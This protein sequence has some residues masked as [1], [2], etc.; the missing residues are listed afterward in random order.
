MKNEKLYKALGVF[1]DTM[2]V[3]VVKTLEKHFP[4]KDW[5]ELLYE[6]LSAERQRNWN[7]N[8]EEFA[9]NG[10]P[11]NNLIDYGNLPSF[12]IGFKE[13][14][15]KEFDDKKDANRLINMLLELADVRNDCQHF[16]DVDADE[17]ERAFSNMK[18]VARLIKD[19]KLYQ[20]IV[21]IA[22]KNE[23][24]PAREKRPRIMVGSMSAS[25]VTNDDNLMAWF[26]NVVPHE[27]IRN[28]VLDE[29][30]FAANLWEVAAGKAPAVYLN[31]ATFFEKTYVT[32]GIRD[33]ASRVVAAMNG[34][35]TQNRVISLKTG[36][37]GG[38]THSLIT[39]Y[40]IVKSGSDFGKMDVAKELLKDG[41]MPDFDNARIAVFTHDTNDVAQGREVDGIT[42]RTLW[43]EIAYQL[44][45]LEAYQKVKENDEK[46]LAPTSVVFKP[47]LEGATPCLILIDEL[48]SY[49]LRAHGKKVGGTTLYNETLSFVQTLTEVV[50]DV[51]RC[52]LILTLPA[53]VTEVGDA[54]MG[55]EILTGLQ[56]RVSRIAANISPV[57]NEEIYEVVRRRLF[58][59][60][61][62]EEVVTSVAARY[63]DMYHNRRTDLPDDCDR[64]EYYRRM[65]KSYPFQPELIDMFR[66]RWGNDSRFQRTRGVLRLLASIVQDL[67]RRRMNLVGTQTLIHTS[68][69]NLENLGNVTGTI[70]DLMGANW[71]TVMHADVY[72]SVSTA[73]KVDNAEGGNN[74][75]QY[76]LVEGI[77][78][79]LLF[80]SVGDPSK[81]GLSMKEL[82]KCMLKPNAFNHND[83]D[84]A[85]NKYEQVAQYMHTSTIGEKRYWFQSK[86]NINIIIN[87]AKD[88]V[89]EA[90]VDAEIVKRLK[91]SLN[92]FNGLKVLVNPSSDIPEQTSLT[93]I[94]MGPEYASPQ[95]SVMENV[96]RYVV[97]ISK[98]KGNSPR[99]YRNTMFF[100]TCT[101]KGKSV[102][103]EKVRNYLACQK[104]QENYPS[105]EREQREDVSKRKTEADKESMDALVHAYSIVLKYSSAS[106]SVSRYDM[107]NYASD[108]ST[109][110]GESVL[111]ELKEEGWLLDSIGRIVLDKN[112]L[113]PTVERPIKI[114]D[115]YEAFLQFDDKPMISGSNAIVQTVNRYCSDGLFN[116]ASGQD[117]KYTRVYH[118]EKVPFLDVY[119]EDYWLVDESVKVEMPDQG[120]KDKPA[121]EPGNKVGESPNGYVGDSA[122]NSANS[123]VKE[124]KR[125]KISGS[126][127][128]DQ[129]TQLMQ[130]FILPLKEN[131]IH[132][133]VEFEAQTTAKN[134]LKKNSTTVKNVKE[135]AAQLGLRFEGEE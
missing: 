50:S 35:E 45:G 34:A 48:A 8:A 108:F 129:W 71:D 39:L 79:T 103:V 124:Y 102:L 95:D 63:K 51:P 115:L 33:I 7:N 53:S 99:I 55:A 70:T 84:G 133:K 78:N 61:I 62:D 123:D 47:V 19:E 98:N 93:A 37:G 43:G 80:A 5:Q 112:K 89:R 65:L 3:Y 49:C 30:I 83:I 135:S 74:I 94:V 17:E 127:A 107:K 12:A 21:S 96:K 31:S 76:R 131:G 13:Q 41:L 106:D 132:I 67:W 126:V 15:I 16:N 105:L 9:D 32:Q 38:K 46:M 86:P 36:F 110:L 2:R 27:D 66:L 1:L 28:S 121:D 113:L 88:E 104:V 40:H 130:S 69:V 25:A 42:I 20:D 100:L 14:M 116:V 82:K 56:N 134:P 128:K 114:K 60:I 81:N 68:D 97:D 75:G 11:Y 101:E 85:L 122:D 57:D 10:T 24:Q 111:T 120:G 4:G 26:N 52:S 125:I 73:F 18:M 29:S 58:E 87:Q 117:G 92:F 64:M 72:G 91:N 119:A 22:G 44:G 77:A 118:E 59:S 23:T 109:Q 54:R 6:K 90:E